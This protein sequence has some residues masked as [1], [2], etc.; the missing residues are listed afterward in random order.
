[1]EAKLCAWDSGNINSF[2]VA[3]TRITSSCAAALNP[4]AVMPSCSLVLSPA[5]MDSDRLPPIALRSSSASPPVR[6]AATIP[7]FITCS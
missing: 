7:I 6:F 5:M 2:T 3:S 4:F 1:M